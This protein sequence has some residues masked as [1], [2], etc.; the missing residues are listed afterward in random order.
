[1]LGESK[2]MHPGMGVVAVVDAALEVEAKEAVVFGLELEPAL[3]VLQLA[4]LG[5]DDLLLEPV[6]VTEGHS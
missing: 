5:F 6:N 1:M 4:L 3:I 2:E